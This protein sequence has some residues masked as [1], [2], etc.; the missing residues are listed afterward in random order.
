[1]LQEN[2]L[3]VGSFLEVAVKTTFGRHDGIGPV[4]SINIVNGAHESDR[5][6]H[7]KIVECGLMSFISLEA[8]L[9]VRLAVERKSRNL[10]LRVC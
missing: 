3:L 9:H 4:G 2:K 5:G 8:T 1:M 10:L 7:E 6:E